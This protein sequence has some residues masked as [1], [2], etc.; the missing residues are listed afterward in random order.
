MEWRCASAISPGFTSW[1]EACTV[2]VA[3]FSFKPGVQSRTVR[4][5]APPSMPRMSP[6]RSRTR[7]ISAQRQRCASAKGRGSGAVTPT[8]RQCPSRSSPSSSALSAARSASSSG[9]TAFRTDMAEPESLPLCRRLFREQAAHALIEVREP[10]APGFGDLPGRPARIHLHLE[11]QLLQ[12][13]AIDGAAA[14]LLDDV[15][16]E[17]GLELDR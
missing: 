2:W 16:Q 13:G 3:H 14:F 4:R 11:A 17:G 15:R 5:E 12:A 6:A 1:K 8:S 7:R 9:A 10:F